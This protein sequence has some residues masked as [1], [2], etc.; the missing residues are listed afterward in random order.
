P[1]PFST[2]VG[3]LMRPEDAVMGEAA[4]GRS[5]DIK[6]W[7]HLL[8]GELIDPY[9][10]VLA[11]DAFPPAVFTANLP[12]GWTPTID[13]S[14]YVRDPGPHEIVKSHVHTRHVTDGWL[15]EDVEMWDSSGRLVAQSRPLALL[16]R[17]PPADVMGLGPGEASS[18]QRRVG[19]G[20]ID[21]AERA[22]E[23]MATVREPLIT[24]A[25]V[26]HH[27]VVATQRT[28]IPK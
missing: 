21:T 3:I 9:G 17:G 4:E 13:I 15:E 2:K 5:P 20:H 22:G 14:V 19:A 12:L 23:P 24:P 27:V 7:F 18:H 1:P 25:F 16:A 11:A 28:E 10:L 6:G 8:D 26:P